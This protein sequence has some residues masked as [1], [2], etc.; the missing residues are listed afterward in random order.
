MSEFKQYK[1]KTIAELRPVIQSDIDM[2]F[3]EF[4]EKVSISPYDA[5]NNSPKLGDMIARNPK[6]HNDLWLVAEQFFKDNY[7]PFPTK[8]MCDFKNKI[9]SEYKNGNIVVASHDRLQVAPIKDVIAQPTQGLLYDLNR[10]ATTILTFIDDPKWINDYACMA[11]IV[12][13]KEE[14]EEL[15]N[16]YKD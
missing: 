7:E 10:D 14:I 15:K 16:Q 4:A 12:A 1:K 13:L 2:D 11:V 3:D 9:L 8:P 5:A 6:D